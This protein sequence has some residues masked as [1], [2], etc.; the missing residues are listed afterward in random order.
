VS[1]VR[2][3]FY[4][5]GHHKP[6]TGHMYLSRES[7]TCWKLVSNHLRLRE[8]TTLEGTELHKGGAAFLEEMHHFIAYWATAQADAIE[9]HRVWSSTKQPKQMLVRPGFRAVTAEKQWNDYKRETAA[10]IALI[11]LDYGIV[12][13][14]LFT[15]GW[16]PT[17]D[18]TP[19]PIFTFGEP[20]ASH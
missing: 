16:L 6:F 13:G 18:L 20:W 14:V 5:Q 15:E 2:F 8:I 10:E 3:K 7:E 12:Q 9:K 19:F 17:P 1:I 11:N 4:A